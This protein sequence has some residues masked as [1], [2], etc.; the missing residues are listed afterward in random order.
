MRS[1][2]TRRLLA[3][4]VMAG[5]IWSAA[6]QAVVAAEPQAPALARV[7]VQPDDPSPA[8]AAPAPTARPAD[9]APEPTPPPPPKPSSHGTADPG[10]PSDR[11]APQGE[12]HTESPAVAPASGPAPAAVASVGGRV[13]KAG[14]VGIGGVW[15][16]VYDADDNWYD[17]AYTASDGT[18]TV[19][20]AAG[21]Y[22][23]LFQDSSRTYMPG[24]YS[25]SGFTPLQASAS[26]VVVGTTPISNI[27]VELPLARHITGKVVG[28]GASPVSDGWVWAYD[29]TGRRR[30]AI[31]IAPDG[32]YS[33][34]VG[35]GS[36]TIYAE[37]S[38]WAFLA[39]WY[40][41][42]G[43]VR[44]GDLATPVVVGAADVTG[45]NI[46]LPAALHIRGQ[47]TGSG[48]VP[49][50]DGWV[51]ADGDDFGISTST[52][53]DGSYEVPVYPGTYRVE[54][55]DYSGTHL[56][57]YYSSGGWVPDWE[58]ATPVVV[59]TADVDGIDVV[60]PV[61][62]HIRGTVTGAGGVPISDGEVAARDASGDWVDSVSTN[63][64]GT[65]SLSV[66][67][68]SYTL[69]F[70][71]Y[72]DTYLSGYY[73]SGGYV[74]DW[75]SASPVAVTTADVDGIDVVLPAALHISGTV[76]GADGLPVADAGVSACGMTSAA[77]ASA[78]SSSSA[79]S[80]DGTA[81]VT[82]R[83]PTLADHLKAVEAS[84][85]PLAADRL[86]VPV[87][88]P[89]D[90]A[91]CIDQAWTSTAADGT[92][93]LSVG[94][95]SYNIEFRD[96]AGVYV[97]GWYSDTGYVPDEASATPVVVDGS[98]VS[99]IDVV[100][101]L[102]LHITGT[103][104]NADGS[105]PSEMQVYAT[106]D[107]GSWSSDGIEVDG[108]YSLSVG[109][110]AYTIEFR[111]DGD[112]HASGW[113]YIA[114][115]Y[116]SG[117]F[118]ASYSEA[119]QVVVTTSD[120][121]GIN[122]TLP[123]LRAVTG[124]VYGAGGAPL[125]EIWVSGWDSATDWSGWTRTDADGRYELPLYVGSYTISFEDDSDTY[126]GGYYSPEGWVPDEG[127][128]TPVVVTTGDVDGIDIVL[129][130]A[131]HI[132]GTVTGAGGVAV[133]DGWVGTYDPA[134]D[135]GSWTSTNA[136]GSYSLSVGPGSYTIQFGDHSGTYLGG[137]Y[138]S[139]GWVPD[140]A[141]ATPVDVTTGDVDGIDIV[142]PVALHIRGT[143]TGAG[144]VPISDGWVNAYDGNGDWVDGNSTNADGSYSL[145]V[146]PGSYNI[147]FY[148]NSGAYAGGWY[149]SGGYVAN[150]AS[151]T[152]VVV[153]TGDVDG[154]NV[155]LP[156]ALRIRGTVT[157]AGG[158]PIDDGEVVA[159]DSTGDSVADGSIMTDGS[160]S[161]PVGPGS[162]TL[163]FLD[164]SGTYI[165]G[166]YS[167]SGW[168]PDQASAT[169][170]VVTTADV[171][172][173]D[174]VLPAV[175][176]AVPGA[177]TGV[178]ADAGQWVGRRRLDGPRLQ[179]RQ[180]RHAVHGH[181]GR[182]QDLH[183][184]G[185]RAH[186]HHHRPHQRHDV[187][188]H[189]DRHQRRRNRP[190]LEPGR[191]G[192]PA[193]RAGRPHRRHRDA[194]QWVD[195]RRL[196][197]PRFHRREFDHLLH[198]H[199]G[200][201][202]DLHGHGPRAHLHHHRPHQRHDVQR[203]RDRHQRRR[204]RPGLE[205]G[206]G[207]RPA[208]RAGRPHRRHRDAG[209]PGR[210]RQV[211][212]PGLQRR[213]CR[214]QLHRHVLRRGQDLHGDRPGAHLHGHRP[215][216]GH[217]LHLHRQGHQRRRHRA[218][219]RGLGRPRGDRRAGRP[220]RRHR[221]AGQRVGPVVKWVAPAS[222]GG[223]AVTKYTATAAAGK[224]CTATA[225]ALT[226]TI[227]GL[228]NGTTYS[229]TVTAT[230]AAGTGPASS[231]A[232]AVV[233]RTVPGAPTGVTATPGNL[234]AVVKWVAPASN[235]GSA[236]TSYT[237]TSSVG[238][239]T[240][241]ATAPA[242][243]C[244][245]TGL[246]K[247]T[248]Y[249]FTVKATNAAGAGPASAASAALVAIAVPGAPTGVTATP[250]NAR[251][252]SSSGSPR[253]P[254]A[255]APS[256]ATPSRP[257]SAAR[258]CT[259]TAPALTCTVTGLT[260][261]TSYTFTVKATNAAGAGPASAASA[262][263]VA[264]AVPGAPTGVTAT[265]GNARPRSSSGSPRPPT[266]AAPSR[267]YTATA[268]A[269]KTCT[270]TAPAL[271]CTIT[272]LTNGTTYS[273]TVTATNAAGTGPASSPAVAVVPRTVPGAPTG[274]TATPGN[275]AAV[276]KWV[277][278][279]SNGGS[280]VTSY[281]VTSSVGARTCTATA[282]ALTCTVTGLT[283]GTSYTFTVKATNAAGAGPAS[284]ASA[285]LVAIAVPGAP[286][287]VTATPGNARPGRQVGRPGLQRR[288]RRH[289]AT[290]PPRPP[291]QDLHG[292]GPRAHLHHHRPHQ[293]HD[294]HRH[295]DRHQRRRNR[296]GLEPG[297]GGRPAHRAGRPHRRHRDAGQPRPRSSS[298]SPRPP[299]A[300]APSPATPSRPPSGPG[301]A[302]RPPRRSPARSPASPRAPPTPSPSR[303]PTPPAPGPRPRPR[304][305][306]WRSPCRAPPPASP[307][308]RATWP[309]SSSGSPR[310]PT[311]A[312]PS[313][314][315]RPPRPP[316]RPARPR[317]PR[318]PAPSPAS[319]T[320]R[321]TASP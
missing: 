198:G 311:A 276:V 218:R 197:G 114:G 103:V 313:R 107:N 44:Y 101:P 5:L 81:S 268:A 31:D 278:P 7:S 304:P 128:A 240:C 97:S 29:A 144:G 13:T 122:V 241:T 48:G 140:R 148:D 1:I 257:P 129:P 321:R 2:G 70:W 203:H 40:S 260:K 250:G 157:G 120:V 222:N 307:R 41:S 154:I 61:A 312:A 239:R 172:E 280:A 226:C 153:T 24:W 51:Y 290:P 163:H 94:P 65:Y 206:R 62:L 320:A 98:D 162:Y 283:K 317:P 288:Q 141:S 49:V 292:H 228:T 54:F 71:D 227:T 181:R 27:N 254:T 215:H 306:W 3:A 310:P 275:L 182:R 36:Y 21:T 4:L 188:R 258:T 38:S 234:A 47:V 80:S 72:S 9:Q 75:E 183:G 264:I 200:R 225:P 299:T 262:A 242:L 45:V 246:T 155:V 161:L 179:R 39:G 42:T 110:G 138:S 223:S 117:G 123:E 209:Q 235:G 160:Y 185:P 119:T 281:T 229:V 259:A 50:S 233:P 177:P 18:Y 53:A 164:Y 63:A 55:Q 106:A 134:G 272:G 159:Y 46:V 293:R 60:L 207:G 269:G 178:T 186:L 37:D 244:T 79:P 121:G 210:R 33:L 118:T 314:S 224:T 25:T 168:V 100:L 193:H 266:A 217:L 169:P 194:G 102:A 230:N 201:R 19:S 247:G 245:V 69:Q 252:R 180:R 68:G 22:T 147:R 176:I 213:Q 52:S 93:T 90:S 92:Y 309:R 221:D 59:T 57:G 305:P 279:A 112:T 286:T 32:S 219:V 58:S 291:G 73:S 30:D 277:A 282:P 130:V 231:P 195:H 133:S 16:D 285:A 82:P 132:S 28:A 43:W 184:H 171:D 76:M 238:A 236:V 265:P 220:H 74:P 298:G 316:A 248:S 17:N 35:P 149:S 104:M 175:A 113:A 166:W 89:T 131:L 105:P 145:P 216:Q 137:W 143:V 139:G 297:R 10:R 167:S 23:F 256:P 116:S 204:N 211:G 253:P 34:S 127:S 84:S 85:R 152:P 301:P 170:V 295:R 124:T 142:L 189:R 15:V 158:V 315:T 91:G 214:H 251:P 284:A 243:T 208:H 274:V 267:S 14:G 78:P 303:P 308:R 66:G 255:A 263:L 190:G 26:G 6:A 115:Y 318:S 126:L 319:P 77:P 136:D 237:V 8:P 99:D 108:S 135:G 202:Q 205:P 95:G 12:T 20:L 296:P 88:S 174:I 289:E 156:A 212:R 294:V 64:D 150:Q 273:V 302:R 287:G 125:A 165:D 146:G 96:Y 196:D 271:T 300:A 83:R 67:P 151:A 270:A 249:T 56:D 111:N 199:R 261:G 86:A 87:A 187:Q 173:I 232:V 191:G 192:R 11:T 109:P